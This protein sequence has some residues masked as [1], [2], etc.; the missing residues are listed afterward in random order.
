MRS[1]T[2][3]LV[4]LC[5]LAMAGLSAT[6]SAAPT[7]LT[8]SVFFPATHK[9]T[10]LATE[11]AREV[12]K[13]TNNAVQ[14]TVFPGGTLTPADKCYDGVEQGISDIGM[15]VLGYT[16]G[17]FPL[18]EVLDL[19]L[20][21]RTGVTATGMVNAFH[22]K[23]AP[24]EFGGTQIMYLHAH[25][26]GL[27]HTKKPVRKLEDLKGMK[28]RC[29]GLAAKS[30]TALGGTP[31]AMSMGETYDSLNRGV[32]DGSM[33]PMESLEGWRWGEVVKYT[34]EDHGAAYTT[35]FF[36]TMNKAKWNSLS[37]DVRKVMAEVNAEW[38][39]RTGKAWDAMDQSGRDFVT[40]RGNEIISLSA[41]ENARWAEAVKPL[42]TEYAA[43]M[44][45]KGLPGEEA[46]AFCQDY[47]KKHQEP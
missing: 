44:K 8:Y 19:P 24:K 21:C 40:K 26:P 36:V 25:G 47:L 6:S 15:S 12:E 29:T 31:V 35:T 38:A 13:R 32:V 42:L 45:E 16:R 3:W 10:L 30:V 2:A 39:E 5:A 22:E 34:T 11:W 18:S 9:N 33:A 7:K 28:I 46:V 20:G 17:R 14:I 1:A 41:E 27:L 43:K 4:G 23:F 37:A